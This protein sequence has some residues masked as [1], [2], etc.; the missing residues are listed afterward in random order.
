[1]FLNID[2]PCT[3]LQGSTNACIL[4]FEL[5][6]SFKNLRVFMRTDTLSLVLQV[7]SYF[8]PLIL[9]TKTSNSLKWPATS[10]KRP[11][12][13][14]NDLQR[15]RNDLQQPETIYKEQDTTWMIYN[16]QEMT[17]NDLQR[18]DSSF[19]EPLY[20]KNNQLEDFSI[21]KNQ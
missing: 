1:M 6:Y 8:F 11:E 15:R 3:Y 18:T 7:S 9:F 2:H 4:A 21:T 17:Y 20:L 10:K 5:V 19:M 14:W 16:E 13:T 12:M